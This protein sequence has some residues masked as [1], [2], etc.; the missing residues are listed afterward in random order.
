MDGRLGGA[1]LGL[2]VL[3]GVL[4]YNFSEKDSDLYEV[5]DQMLEY[6]MELPD[7]DRYGS[8]YLDWFETYHEIAFENNYEMGGRVG[9]RRYRSADFDGASYMFELFDGMVSAAVSAGYEEQAEHLRAL[10]ERL[11]WDY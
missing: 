4:F 9:R 6:I 7:Y 2:L 5:H 11:V 3:V 8:L 1:V 10:E